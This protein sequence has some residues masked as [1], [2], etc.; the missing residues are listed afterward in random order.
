MKVLCTD[1]KIVNAGDDIK[2]TIYKISYIFDGGEI[3][4]E[5]EGNYLRKGTIILSNNATDTLSNS[6]I[7]VYTLFEEEDEIELYFLEKINGFGEDLIVMSKAYLN[8]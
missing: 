3:I 4:T 8:Q 2:T 5:N 7:H 6:Y 1:Q